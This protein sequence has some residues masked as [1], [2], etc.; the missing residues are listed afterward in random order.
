MLR[1]LEL[2]CLGRQESFEIDYLGGAYSRADT[3]EVVEDI[4]DSTCQWCGERFYT[5]EEDGIEFCVH[6]GTF[7]RRR[8]ERYQD[9]VTWAREQD[10]GF[11][12]FVPEL[13]AFAVLRDTNWSLRFARTKEELEFRGTWSDVKAIPTV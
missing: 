11:L 12:R 2:V 10:W 6:C 9:L 7:D 13:K 1:G 3:G 5:R 8:F 4:L